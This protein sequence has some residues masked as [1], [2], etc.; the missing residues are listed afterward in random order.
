MSQKGTSA[1]HSSTVNAHTPADRRVS[2]Y[3]SGEWPR[4]GERLTLGDPGRD[5]MRAG[6]RVDQGGVD[7]RYAV[8]AVLPRHAFPT[9]WAHKT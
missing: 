6:R 5:E 9:A 7:A 4:S 1:N 2:V 3:G 8:L